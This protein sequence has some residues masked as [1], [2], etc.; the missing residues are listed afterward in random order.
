MK[1]LL[2]ENVLTTQDPQ[3]KVR[4]LADVLNRHSGHLDRFIAVTD[5]RIRVRS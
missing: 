1:F 5:R 2:D 3:A 4:R